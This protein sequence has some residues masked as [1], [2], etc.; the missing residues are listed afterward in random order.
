MA[1][2]VGIVRQVYIRD[3]GCDRF[4]EDLVG[5][6]NWERRIFCD[7]SDEVDR[8]ILRIFEIGGVGGSFVGSNK[9]N[10]FGDA[11]ALDDFL[12][13]RNPTAQ[14]AIVGFFQVFFSGF[15][16]VD[17]KIEVVRRAE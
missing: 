4:G 11:I 14:V 9:E 5:T 10:K 12:E 7:F 15:V 6:G 3:S 2:P 17:K 16:E 13:N 8:G 1:S